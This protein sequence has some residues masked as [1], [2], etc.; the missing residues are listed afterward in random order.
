MYAVQDVEQP[1]QLHD[2]YNNGS[3]IEAPS[4]NNVHL[5]QISPSAV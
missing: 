2:D 3:S 4:R 1:L 5:I